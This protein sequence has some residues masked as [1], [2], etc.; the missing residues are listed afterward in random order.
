VV[1]TVN[2][3][4]IQQQ[5]VASALEALDL[6]DMAYDRTKQRFIIGKA[7]IN[8]LT[9][10]QSRQQSANTN[11][12]QALQNFWESYYRLRKLTLYDFEFNRPLEIDIE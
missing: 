8:S 11:Y 3:F 9:L 6:A 7:D 2:D 4:N 12:I 5:L 10:S 1:I